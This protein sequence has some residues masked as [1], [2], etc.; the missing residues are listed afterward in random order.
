M[1]FLLFVIDIKTHCDI[2]VAALKIQ[3]KTYAE[4]GK[5]NMK[6][7]ELLTTIS[8]E[9]ITNKE[10]WENFR[11]PEIMNLMSEY[12]YGVRP[13]ERPD[14]LHFKTVRKEDGFGE[15]NILFEKIEVCFKG[16]SFDV[17]AYLPND[18]KEKVP[19]FI[20]VMHEFQEDKCNLDESIECENVDIREIISRGFAVFIMPT[21]KLAPDW[22]HKAN[23]K[24]GIYPLFETERKDNSWATISAWSWGASRVMDYIETDERID[25]K[26]VTVIG[27]SRGGKTALWCG[28]NDKRMYCAIS[29]D[30]GCAGA[31]MHRTKEGE[32]IKDINITDWFCKNYHKF[33]DR[34]EMLPTDQHML[35][36][37][38]APR[39][40]YVASSSEDDWA[41]PKAERFSC[42][43]A[44]EAYALYG[45]DGVILPDEPVEI[46][47][48][49]HDGTI[50]YHVKTGE[51]GIDAFDWKMYLDFLQKKM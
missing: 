46:N 19:A 23:Y 51:H 14:D 21:R 17:Y 20:Y 25:S 35:I 15:K 9:K 48:A 34:E 13:V 24:E 1:I 4:K 29:N 50:G 2:I 33:N 6:I 42:R 11:R 44:G 30:S 37:A 39:L 10:D 16:Y 26:K 31:A 3:K 12:I 49:Y 8:G 18:K 45:K 47:K 32:H 22:E 43:M 7:P 28:A 36:A 5:E 27:H 40:C 41:D 38:M